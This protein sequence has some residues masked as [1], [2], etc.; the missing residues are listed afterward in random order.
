MVLNVKKLVPDAILPARASADAVGY[1]LYA[2][3]ECVVKPGRR[4]VVPLGISVKLPQ[5]GR[6]HV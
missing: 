6:A 2:I 3:D 4:T 1:D 5:I